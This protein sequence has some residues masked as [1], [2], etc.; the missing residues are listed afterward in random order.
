MKKETPLNIEDLKR[1][2]NNQNSWRER[3]SAVNELKEYDCQQSRDI[4]ARLA[5]HDIVFTV[6]EAAFMATQ[7]L[8]VTKG[9]QPIYLG[10]KPKG[11]LVDGINKKLTRVRD[12]L[13]D[14]YSLD[15]FKAAFQKLYPA[16]YDA[17][18]GDK[19]GQFDKWL[20]NVIPS[21]PK[22]K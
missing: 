17:Y 3:L 19:K 22:K 12:S 16:A 10:K 20:S 5:I 14:G 2:A 6:K 11:N 9:G 7:A 21:L 4:L 15:D 18:E 8:G 1:M 13:P